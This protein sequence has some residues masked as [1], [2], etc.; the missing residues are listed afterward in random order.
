M[1]KLTVELSTGDTLVEL[2]LI[3]WTGNNLENTFRSR[4]PE[5]NSRL[6][7]EEVSQTF[8]DSEGLLP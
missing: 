4:V 6:D 7:T 3:V 8:M 5:A 1:I 2:L